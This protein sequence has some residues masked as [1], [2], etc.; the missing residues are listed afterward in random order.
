MLSR[1]S[2]RIK[3]MQLLYSLDRDS[4]LAAKDL[5]KSYENG[6]TQSYDLFLFSIYVLMKITENAV[7]DR[8]NRISK[9]LPSD[10]DKSF[11]DKI[12]SN[13]IIQDIIKNDTLQKKFEK[14]DFKSFINQDYTKK[15][16]DE[17]SKSDF[18]KTY[19]NSS[20]SNEDH[21]E[22]LLELYRFCRQNELFNEILEDSYFNWL[23]DKSLVVGAVKKYLKAL[24]NTNKNFF[25]DFL[26]ED[27]TVEEFGLSLLK[28]T[29]K[30]KDEIMEL[31]I[32]VLDNWDHE[33]LAIID[34]ILLRLALCEFMDFPTIPTKV[35]LNEYVE[36]AKN[37]STEKSKEFINGILDKLMKDLDA[38][39][40]LKK[41]GRGLVEE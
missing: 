35:T 26:P 27:E 9:H 6:V 15:I 11:T 5:I 4:T 22:L 1:R 14:L 37:Y 24:P 13:V 7:A 40:L 20:S 28:N 18:Y 36:M 16:Y 17:F 31:I 32:P 39:G 29:I 21:T 19:I 34:T 25:R 30:N 23:D 2:V 10:Y 33:R 38:K 41:Q 12:Y 8:D 3:V